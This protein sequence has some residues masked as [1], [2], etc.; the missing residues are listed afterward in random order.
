MSVRVLSW[1]LDNSEAPGNDRLVLIA[2][3][4][5]ADDDGANAYPSIDRIARRARV[6]KRTTMRA[7]ERLEASGELVV[8][9]PLVTGRGHHNR[10]AV[11]MGRPIEEVTALLDACGKGARVA[12][13]QNGAERRATAR[14]SAPKG[15]PDPQTHGP[16]D[17]EEIG[18]PAPAPAQVIVEGLWAW[19]EENGKPRP[20]LRANGKAGPDRAFVA[21]RAIVQTLLDAGNDAAAIKRAL[22]RTRAWTLDAIT[23]EL[24]S[25]EQRRPQG[26]RAP[27]LAD[28]S[29][30]SG[31]VEL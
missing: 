21:L 1:V 7:L 16:T 28:R 3:A 13:I 24:R 12:P 23:Y 26:Q 4:D 30:P 15:A 9:R 20:T 17:P 5:E 19:C 22:T 8:D 2:I 27:V 18:P 25:E 6:N 10:Y 14:K 29:R 11:V 31:V